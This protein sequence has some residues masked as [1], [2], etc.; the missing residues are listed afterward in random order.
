MG[1]LDPATA[2]RYRQQ[3]AAAAGAGRAAATAA[4][5]ANVRGREQEQAQAAAVQYSAD[6]GSGMIRL[7][8][9]YL[10]TALIFG[11][12]GVGAYFLLRRPRARVRGRR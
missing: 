4:A 3:A 9:N 1:T 7:K 10:G 2:E 12:V 6:T 11:A 5:A 8:P